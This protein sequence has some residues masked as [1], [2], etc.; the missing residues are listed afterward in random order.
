VSPVKYEMRFYIIV[1]LLMYVVLSHEREELLF[2]FAAV[3]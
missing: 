3:P 2:I 1:A